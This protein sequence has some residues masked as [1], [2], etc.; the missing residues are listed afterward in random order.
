MI[1]NSAA[2]T[3]I[4]IACGTVNPICSNGKPNIANDSIRTNTINPN[5]FIVLI[6]LVVMKI[7]VLVV[8]KF[9]IYEKNDEHHYDVRHP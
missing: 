5:H 7:K 2:Q 9:V 6:V 1:I 4:N 8:M 3:E